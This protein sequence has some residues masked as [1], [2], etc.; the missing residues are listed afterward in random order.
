[1]H[2]SRTATTTAGIA[3]LLAAIC[4][5]A[6]AESEYLNPVDGKT[7]VAPGGFKTYQP[8][9]PRNTL[10]QRISTIGVILLTS[11]ADLQERTSVQDLSVFLK[12]VE[13]KAYEVLARNKSAMVVL[14]QFNC[15]PGKCA[16][17]LASQGEAE[18]ATLQKL[19]AVLAGVPALRTSGEAIFQLQIRVG[20]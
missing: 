16:V 13:A 8:E 17:K 6:V 9:V 10:G 11:Q 14:V 7:Y 18:S 4:S 3:W 12:S 19:Y 20:A 15:A 5:A 2:T 1:M